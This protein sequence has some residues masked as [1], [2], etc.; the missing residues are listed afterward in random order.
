MLVHEAAHD[1]R[2]KRN[3]TASSASS[4]IMK[5]HQL[6]QLSTVLNACVS[7]S[8]HEVTALTYAYQSAR[9]TFRLQNRHR[10][11]P[12][13][14]VWKRCHVIAYAPW[15]T[16]C[17]FSWNLNV[18]EHELPA[19]ARSPRVRI[20][21][22]SWHARTRR[23]VFNSATTRVSRCPQFAGSKYACLNK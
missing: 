8:R 19:L 23:L 1:D 22:V 15:V 7:H 6:A 9:C 17:R 16:N 18:H 14:P 2:H 4:I 13:H 10:A 20:V 11:V 5:Y 12:N 21:Q 3:E